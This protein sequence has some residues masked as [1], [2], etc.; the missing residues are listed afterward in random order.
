[1]ASALKGMTLSKNLMPTEQFLKVHRLHKWTLKLVR[2]GNF[3]A[4]FLCVNSLK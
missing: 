1:M 3:R 4:K 2:L